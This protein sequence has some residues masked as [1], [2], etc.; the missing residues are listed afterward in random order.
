MKLKYL[1]DL[2]DKYNFRYIVLVHFNNAIYPRVYCNCL[3]AI[4]TILILF[5]Y[6]KGFPLLLDILMVLLLCYFQFIIM[7]EYMNNIIYWRV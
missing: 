3:Y 6:D 1:A 7:I 2:S 4:K 5:S